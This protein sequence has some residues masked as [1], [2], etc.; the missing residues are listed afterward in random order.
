V[1]KTRVNVGG[2]FLKK[3]TNYI[4]N[5][6]LLIVIIYVTLV[7]LSLILSLGVSVNYNLADYLPD[8]AGSK[9]AIQI[10]NNEFE[11]NGSANLL[12]EDMSM[13]QIAKV[14]QSVKAIDGVKD[15]IWLDD[16]ADITMPI[17][18]IDQQLKDTYYLEEKALIQVLFEEN[19]YENKTAYAIGEIEALIGDHGVLTG[20]AVTSTNLISSLGSSIIY[21]L[22]LA[23]VIII[24]ILILSTTSYFEVLLFL[25][26]IGVSVLINNGTNIIFGEIS[27]MT[28]SASAILQIAIAMDYSIFLLHR[29]SEEREKV[30]DPK[31]AMALAIRHSLS[32]ISA[33]A[34]T[35]IVGFLALTFMS[36]RIGFDMGLVLAKGILISMITILTLLPV[37]ALLS[38]KPIRKTTHRHFLPSFRKLE[39]TLEKGRYIILVV[40]VVL[41][42]FGLLGQN[43]NFFL[44]GAES[45][46]ASDQDNADMSRVTDVFGT[47][48]MAMLIIPNGDKVSEN[49]MVNDIKDIDTVIGVTGM[50]ALVDST[51]PEFIIPDALKDQFVSENYTRYF[52]DLNTAVESDEAFSTHENILSIAGKYYET[53]YIT[54]QTPSTY[55]IKMVSEKDFVVVNTISIVAVGVILLITFQSILLPILLLFVIQASIWINMSIPYYMGTEML[56]IGY[57]IVS[58]MQL[59]ATIDYAIL[60]TNRYKENRRFYGSHEAAVEAIGQAGHSIFTSATIL[61]AAGI[62]IGVVFTQPSMSIMGLLIG[63]GAL[64]SGAMVMFAL[65][66]LLV[67]FD[68]AI[69]MTTLKWPKSQKDI[70]RIEKVK[71]MKKEYKVEKKRRTRIRSLSLILVLLLATM[72]VMSSAQTVK[73]ETIYGTLNFDGSVKEIT[74]VNRLQSDSADR[75]LIDFGDYQNIINL[76]GDQGPAVQGDK[77]TWTDSS[78]HAGGFFYQGS[79][80]KALPYVFNIRYYLDGIKVDAQSLAGKSGRIRIEID[81]EQ[82]MRCP[83]KVRKG[84]MAQIALTLDLEKVNNVVNKNATKVVAGK[85]MTLSYTILAGSDADFVVS[86]DAQDF[87]MNGMNITMLKGE[88]TVPDNLQDS[89]DDIE[90]GFIEMADGMDE[91]IDGTKDLKSGL[92]TVSRNANKMDDGLKGLASGAYEMASGIKDY[93]QGIA[94]LASGSSAIKGGLSALASKGGDLASGLSAIS[95]GNDQ[96]VALAILLQSSNDPNAAA[97]AAGVIAQGAAITALKDGV[98]PENQGLAAYV[99]G[100][101]ALSSQYAGL[102]DGIQQLAGSSGGITEIYDGAID[103]ADGVST[104][105]D[106]MHDFTRGVGKLPGAA[107]ELVDG[108]IEFKDGIDEANEDIQK[109][110]DD[111]MP[112]EQADYVSFVSPDKN[113]PSSVQYIL[114]TPAIE[115][116]DEEEVVKIEEQSKNI[117]NRFVDLFVSKKKVKNN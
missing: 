3:I 25:V 61:G 102:D 107:Q 51:M 38:E 33:S 74:A 43:S 37:L 75:D 7:V 35:T 6:K 27:F 8:E 97:L 89:L 36:F 56:F 87:E 18:Q 44:Y 110:V 40:V 20:P 105:S 114:L 62:I 111:A 66:Q 101:S 22:I 26:T 117:W 53:Y 77:I 85:M 115:M 32:S 57:L 108:Q 78:M 67:I 100:V 58:A 113:K 24:S 98:P 17:Q 13:T 64:I 86:F 16:V 50:Y 93:K 112:A 99:G 96:L 109:Q 5:H 10:L 1:F 73:D 106:G 19:D 39:S 4:V 12:L 72:P 46:Q 116:Q 48:N 15:A 82:N 52:I 90:S 104:M 47:Q 28:S 55:D 54:G 70:N 23:L 2:S 81:V 14:K 84:I 79:I 94:P 31:Q 71:K 103:Y 88:I 83:E 65:P 80:D 41:S 34:V 42:I 76:V 11:N 69:G 92:S 91:M 29:F 95:D 63:R 49:N 30:D 60:L 45:S 59:G 68:R 9:K 21:G